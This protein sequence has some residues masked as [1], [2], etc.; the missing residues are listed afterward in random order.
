M[1]KRTFSLSP[2]DLPVILLAILY[3]FGG[4][5][6]YGGK[7][8]LL[9][10]FAAVAL[11]GAFFLAENLLSNEAALHRFCRLFSVVSFFVALLGILSYLSG[12]AL[13][14]W[15]D[16][17]MF[18]DI[19]GR[20]SVLFDNANILA[21]YLLPAAPVALAMAGSQRSGAA[22]LGYLLIFL[23]V[24]AALLVTWSRGAWL[25]ILVALLVYC[26]L[27]GGASPVFVIL[28][29][30]GLPFVPYFLPETVIQ[31]FFSALAPIL[32]SGVTDSSISYRMQIWR[33]TAALLRD[34]G[35]GGIGVGNDAFASVYP[36]YALSGSETAVHTH[37][38]YLQLL[39]ELGV[40]GGVA[41]LLLGA[42]LFFGV[43]SHKRLERR[44]AMRTLHI[45]I[46]TAILGVLVMG[47]GDDVFY[48]PRIFCL[49]FLLAGVASALTKLG[50]IRATERSFA[51]M[52]DESYHA[53]TE[54]SVKK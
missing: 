29:G 10:G 54:I 33:G 26:L 43:L 20:I 3:L 42:L 40:M 47:L 34:H 15:L 49:V 16:D 18:K 5:F 28:F 1:N 21:A 46:F 9:S 45:G 25:G 23:A 36:Q 48:S 51:V 13:H 24:S 50:H 4:I 2:L 12:T 6:S 37:S 39:T 11:L 31:R 17:S 27:S 7:E 53:Q 14:E 38:L 8:S 44:D 19:P 30:V 52:H 35:I 32:N 22:R 41:I